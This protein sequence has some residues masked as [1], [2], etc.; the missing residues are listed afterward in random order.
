MINALRPVNTS[1]DLK[2]PIVPDPRQ[3]EEWLVLYSAN[4][5][6][7]QPAK[8]AARYCALCLNPSNSYYLTLIAITKPT[9]KMDYTN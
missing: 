4:Q 5:G 8:T 1:P 7:S 3:A 6:L 2:L 9:F